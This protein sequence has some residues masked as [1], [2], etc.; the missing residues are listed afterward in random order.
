M[1]I[2]SF[3]ALASSLSSAVE[4]GKAALGA[5]DTKL[6]QESI[7][8]LNEEVLNAQQALFNAQSALLQ[9]QSEHFECT[10]QLRRLQEALDDRARYA[11]FEF[12][13][14]PGNFAYRLKNAPALGTAGEPVGAEPMHYLC[15]GCFDKGVKSILART[16]AA[17][18]GLTEIMEACPNCERVIVMTN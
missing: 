11:L 10:Q 1:D 5:R 4:I 2:S 16:V 3:A 12:P 15:Q 18:I 6:V 8:R 7:A 17:T 9:L 13:S 14:A